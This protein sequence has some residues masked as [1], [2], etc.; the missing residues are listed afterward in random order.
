[1]V[2]SSHWWSRLVPRLG[3]KWW[4]RSKLADLSSNRLILI[5]FQ[6][7][8]GMSP[9]SHN[10]RFCAGNQPIVEFSNN[11]VQQIQTR[12][13]V[14]AVGETI[15]IATFAC[16]FMTLMKQHRHPEEGLGGKIDSFYHRGGIYHKMIMREKGSIYHLKRILPRIFGIVT[17]TNRFLIVVA[18]LKITSYARGEEIELIQ[19]KRVSHETK[20][21]DTFQ[22]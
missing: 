17:K 5:I 8:S 22:C 7:V 11:L 18:F 14:I 2:S 21:T 15:I 10:I 6:I 19:R 9:A 1:M 3:S 13:D 12:S 16:T 4:R 20:K